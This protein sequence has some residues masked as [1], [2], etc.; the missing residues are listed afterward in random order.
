MGDGNHC[1]NCRGSLTTR[2]CRPSRMLAHRTHGQRKRLR[3]L[4]SGVGRKDGAKSMMSCNE[5]SARTSRAS[6]SLGKKSTFPSFREKNPSYGTS[7]TSHARAVKSRGPSLGWSQGKASVLLRWP[8][9]RRSLAISKRPRH[10]RRAA[11]ASPGVELAAVR[12]V[13]S[14]VG[15]HSGQG[16]AG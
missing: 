13:N 10:Y 15:G 4:L 14:A 11:R 8:S 2:I 1:P 7:P 16:E 6:T 12:A 9:L 3:K 5:K